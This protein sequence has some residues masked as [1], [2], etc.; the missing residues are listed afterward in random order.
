MANGN[1]CY[2]PT[3]GEFAKG[4]YEVRMFKTYSIQAYTEDV[5][6]ALI[7]ESVKTLEEII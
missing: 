7:T 3:A 2:L 5:D 1:E 6:Y 4:G